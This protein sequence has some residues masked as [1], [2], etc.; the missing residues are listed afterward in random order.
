[1]HH[2]LQGVV[3]METVSGIQETEVVA[4]CQ[5]DAFVH[6]II[7][8]FVRFANKQGDTVAIPFGNGEG[9]V[10]GCTVYDD[11]LYVVVGL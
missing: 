10:F 7:Q 2:L 11:V 5:V 8:S 1:M 6:G 9:A 4:R 3:F